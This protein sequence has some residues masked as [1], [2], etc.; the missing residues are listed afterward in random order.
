MVLGLVVAVAAA[1]VLVGGAASAWLAWVDEPLR[2]PGQSQNITLPLVAAPA[3]T[4]VPT[5]AAPT[6]AATSAPERR[7]LRQ[8]RRSAAPTSV[9][10]VVAGSAW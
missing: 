2:R 6:R 7:R 4:T 1:G 3:A 8:L 9:P 5:L 10:A